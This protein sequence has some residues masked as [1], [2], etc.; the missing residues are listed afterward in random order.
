MFFSS[1]GPAY[2][3]GVHLSGEFTKFK[4][5]TEFNLT[6]FS[7]WTP[8]MK[9][10][11]FFVNDVLK[12]SISYN[13][14]KCYHRR[15]LCKPAECTCSDGGSRFTWSFDDDSSIIVF[16]CEMRFIDEETSTVLVQTAT[17]L[18]NDT[19]KYK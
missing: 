2:S 4:N 9:S 17:L 15:K 10:V 7:C 14:E 12:D 6:C 18:Y 13:N 1:T 19:G 8:H 16:A 11:T 5:H 3:A